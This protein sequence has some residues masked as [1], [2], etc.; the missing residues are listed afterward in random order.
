MSGGVSNLSDADLMRMLGAGGATPPTAAPSAFPT[1]ASGLAGMSDADLMRQLGQAQM[2]PAATPLTPG[3]LQIRIGARPRQ[4]VPNPFTPEDARPQSPADTRPSFE[5]LFRGDQ[6]AP[7]MASTAGTSSPLGAGLQAKADEAVI[8]KPSAG[9]DVAAALLSAMQGATLN[10]GGNAA[11]GAATL[12]G[13]VG[14]PG[15]APRSFSENYQRFQ[16]LLSA[17]GRQSPKSAIAG[18]V[19]GSLLTAPLLPSL[20]GARAASMARR[21]GQAAIN[22][23]SYGAA[24]EAIDSRD[25]WKVAG[26]GLIGAGAGGILSPAI[27]KLAPPVLNAATQALAPLAQRFGFQVSKPSGGFSLEAQNALRAAGLDPATLPAELA[28]HLQNT[29]K[30]KGVSPAAIREGQAAEFGI[31]LS[32]G[33]ATQSAADILRERLFLSG[34]K[35]NGAQQA[36]Q[37]FLDQQGKASFNAKDVLMQALAGKRSVID[38]PVAASEGVADVA[39]RLSERTAFQASAAQ[40]T[41]DQ[42]LEGVRGRGAPD[43][44]DAA[45][46]TAQALREAANQGRAGYR[47]AY[48]EV[49]AIPGQF[50]PGAL[51]RMGTRLLSRLGADV[52]VDDVLTPS[53]TRALADLDALP[54]IFNLDHGGGPDL[55]QVDQLRKRLV[56]YRGATAQNPTDRRA[57][58]RILREFDDHVT[59]AMDLGQFGARATGPSP[60]AADDFPG[61]ALSGVPDSAAAAP[62]APRGNPET[63]GQFIARNGGMELSGDVRA[64]DLHKWR[65]GG[66]RPLAREGGTPI[67]A[68]RDKL[69]TAGFI[70]PDDAHGAIA[71]DIRG[72]VMEALRA[73]RAGRPTYRFVDEERAANTRRVSDQ[74][75]DQNADHAAMLDRQARR[76][77]IDLEGYGLRSQDLDRSALSD[78]AE[79]MVLGHA[80]DAATAYE[81]AVARRASAADDRGFGAPAPTP[82]DTPFPELGEGAAASAGSGF[83]AGD[84]APAEAMR[85]ARGLFSQYKATFAPR[86]SGD[87]VGLAMRRI[88]ERDATPNEVAT[89]LY[90]GTRP[91]SSGISVRIHDRLADALGVD[92]PAIEAIRQGLISKVVDGGPGDVVTRLDHLL[93][94]DGRVLAERVLTADQRAGLEAFRVGSMRARNAQ[95]ALP[96]WV[97]RLGDTGFDP[98]RVTA[99]LFGSGIP[100]ARPG[101]A[102]FARGLRSMLGADSPEWSGL[103]QAAWMRLVQHGE[104][105][106]LRPARE[107]ERIRAFTQGEGKGL[108]TTLFST[109]ELAQMNRY[110]DVVRAIDIPNGGRL[111]D[112]GRA[113]AMAGHILNGLAGVVGFKVAGPAGAAGA[114]GLKMGQRLAQGGLASVQAGQAFN[115]GAPRVAPEVPEAVQRLGQT[116]GRAAGLLSAAGVPSRR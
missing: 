86:G 64:N 103:R 8:G 113:S 82:H 9:N 107:A 48:D 60:A 17:H 12:A 29:F 5:D 34:R 111:P 66:L 109:D 24:S 70:R 2:A 35:G 1:P 73:E 42:A 110:A 78:A 6:A 100:G 69:V 98:N 50:T 72:E 77:A 63:M 65:V 21:A 56:A 99:D 92:H 51:D 67:D 44:I 43:Q 4:D 39:R 85:H 87:D 68:M 33:Q 13:K 36:G 76:M 19:G 62:A 22:G 90:G 80:D 14:L 116:A 88:V 59:D 46:Q 81:Q 83:P 105:A 30:A 108:A 101:Q 115:G 55:R 52:P 11:A 74:V 32:R 93:R 112:G 75:A 28:S 40:R 3:A 20:T 71:R 18:T 58:D 106:P 84:T 97:R 15:Y 49:A 26:A 61:F 102:D 31:P 47:A 53:A 23:A 89:M 25:G 57:M 79:R 16:D 45:A 38:S 37:G 104:A 54:G 10:V 27:E 96:D 41:A 94:G 7:V 95:E 114:Y 91:G